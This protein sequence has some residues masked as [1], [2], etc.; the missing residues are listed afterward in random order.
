MVERPVNLDRAANCV[1]RP[2][3]AARYGELAARYAANP[4]GVTLYAE[5]CRRAILAAERRILELAGASA[6]E[7]RL[8]W[9]ASATEAA[10]LALRGF[11]IGRAHV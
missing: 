9:C 3:L 5:E 11:Q 4:H 6:D 2:G 10:N 8:V 7:A 1:M